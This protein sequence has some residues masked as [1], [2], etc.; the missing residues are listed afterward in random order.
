MSGVCLGAI[1]N[2]A[3]LVLS[4]LQPTSPA[5]AII[6]QKPHKAIYNPSSITEPRLTINNVQGFLFPYGELKHLP[7]LDDPV[8]PPVPASA[9][10]GIVNAAI[11]SAPFLGDC[12]TGLRTAG[13]GV[14]S[15]KQYQ[16]LPVMHKRS[17]GVSAITT[18]NL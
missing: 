8:V 11:S 14:A 12:W 18:V 9:M 7:A 17:A 5:K 1:I 2:L 15:T 13:A 10:A 6:Q 4:I 16:P 3:F